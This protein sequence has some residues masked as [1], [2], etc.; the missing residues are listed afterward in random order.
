MRVRRWHSPSIPAAYHVPSSF[1]GVAGRSTGSTLIKQ[2]KLV[3]DWHGMQYC[4]AE[5]V[6]FEVSSSNDNYLGF[7]Y[8]SRPNRA[9]EITILHLNAYTLINIL[10]LV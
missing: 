10:Y 1:K 3:R 2:Q 5:I 8:Y 6:V 4:E 7:I 9:R